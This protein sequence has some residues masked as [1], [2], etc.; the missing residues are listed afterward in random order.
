[1]IFKS[2]EM[3]AEFER[4]LFRTQ[5]KNL[6][7]SYARTIHMP[8]ALLKLIMKANDILVGVLFKFAEAV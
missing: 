6:M 5:D 2:R 3:A 8:G 1:M 4:E 7:L